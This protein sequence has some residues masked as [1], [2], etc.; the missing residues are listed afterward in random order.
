MVIKIGWTCGICPRCGKKLCRR[1]PADIA[2][3]DCWEN[4][5]QDHGSGPYGTKMEP[6]TPDLTPSTYGPI[7]VVSGTAWGD[8]EHPMQIV[9]RCP[10]CNYHSAAKPQEVRLS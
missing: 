8:L 9:R 4:C 10:I 6:Y 2:V 3:C 7:E 5:P 1:R